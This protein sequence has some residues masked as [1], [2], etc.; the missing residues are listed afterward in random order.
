MPFPARASMTQL[1][2][3][4]PKKNPALNTR[5]QIITALARRSIVAGESDTVWVVISCTASAARSTKVCSSP[6]EVEQ[7]VS[8]NG[9]NINVAARMRDRMVGLLRSGESDSFAPLYP[10]KT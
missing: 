8:Q 5:G 9:N 6:G 3:S 4:P 2:P 1:P 7:A 10:V